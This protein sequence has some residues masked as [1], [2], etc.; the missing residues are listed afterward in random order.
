MEIPTGEQLLLLSI[1]ST[2]VMVGVWTVVKWL[3]GPAETHEPTMRRGWQRPTGGGHWVNDSNGGGYQPYDGG[4]SCPSGLC[5]AS[6][7]NTLTAGEAQAHDASRR[8]WFEAEAFG[9]HASTGMTR[10]EIE[11]GNYDAY[12]ASHPAPAYS[13][14]PSLPSGS[15][16][17]HNLPAPAHSGYNLPSGAA[18]YHN[19]LPPVHDA[20][21]LPGYT[22]LPAYQ[23]PAGHGQP[24]AMSAPQHRWSSPEIP[25][26]SKWGPPALDG[27]ETVEGDWKWADSRSGDGD[28]V[29]INRK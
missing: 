7:S 28:L 24:S 5:T 22:P 3:F 11:Q 19:A 8:A 16:G 27:N 10:A 15:Q 12:V 20:P 17:G 2:A 23:L 21:A 29:P 18:A 13:A 9:E 6:R 26:A 25:P 1:I 4:S 14:A